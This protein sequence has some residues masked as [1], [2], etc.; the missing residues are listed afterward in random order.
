MSFSFLKIGIEDDSSSSISIYS[1]VI[2]RIE[3][4][5]ELMHFILMRIAL[6]VFLVPSSI[7]T[8]YKYFV[9]GLGEA[10][11]SDMP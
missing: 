3:R 1:N 5:S 4:F 7:V 9:L 2:A 8:P 6:A 10:S 11:F